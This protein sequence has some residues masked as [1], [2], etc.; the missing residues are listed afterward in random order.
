MTFGTESDSE[1]LRR[2]NAEWANIS[3]QQEVWGIEELFYV[4]EVVKTADY[5]GNS[6]NEK[7]TEIVETNRKHNKRLISSKN[8]ML[9]G[10]FSFLFLVLC[11]FEEYIFIQQNGRAVLMHSRKKLV[12]FVVSGNVTHVVLHTL[13]PTSHDDSTR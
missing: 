11:K 7:N 1:F 2:E 9:L 10:W 13:H 5:L 8:Q 12:I 4:I 3:R 6:F